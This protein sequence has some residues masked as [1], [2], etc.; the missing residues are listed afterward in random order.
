M[1]F[2]ADEDRLLLRGVESRDDIEVDQMG[3]STF[4]FY[5]ETRIELRGVTLTEEQ[6]WKLVDSE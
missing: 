4:V 2:D 1:D 6:V 5:G 3:G